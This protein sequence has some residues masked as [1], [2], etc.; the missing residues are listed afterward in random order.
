[1]SPT[2]TARNALATFAAFAALSWACPADAQIATTPTQDPAAL[3]AALST[4]G[5]GLT[6]TSALIRTG[7]PGQMGTYTNFTTLPVSI[8]DGVVLSSGN[9]A[10]IG[11]LAEVHDP[12]YE[13]SSPPLA[14]NSAMSPVFGGGTP[15]FN[16]YGD[17]SGNIHNFDASYDVAALQVQ[18]TLAAPSSIQFDFIF[19]S[20]EFPYWTSRYTDAFLVF[21][22]GTQPENQITFDGNGK[23]VQVGRSFADL[24]M[25]SDANTAFAAPH[26]LIHHLT[27]TSEVLAAGP[28][29]IIFEV[30]DVN[31]QS[32]DSAAFIANLRTGSAPAGTR[33]SDD[34]RPDYD[35][36]G[37]L[38]IQ[39]IF[40]FLAGWF[41]GQ[42]DADFDSSGTIDITD[43]FGFLSNWFAGC[44]GV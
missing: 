20:V 10:S 11:P 23:P 36:S 2:N 22:D 35:N 14:V 1:M 24:T 4:A 38:T 17:R 44:P 25:T 7:A 28:H 43:I 12:A 29:T 9:V 41:D 3:A 40:A 8:R 42:R 33:P 19:G 26:G 37:T 30:G 39:D 18:F 15:E 5:G 6:I 34:C 16:T 31:D 27:T 13:P 32:L 21:L